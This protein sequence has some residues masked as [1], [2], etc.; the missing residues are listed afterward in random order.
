MVDGNSRSA[1]D[2]V[3]GGIGVDEVR[4]LGF[5]GDLDFRTTAEVEVHHFDQLQSVMLFCTIVVLAGRACIYTNSDIL[6]SE[7]RRGPLGTGRYGYG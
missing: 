6:N 7:N 4:L 1:V 5:K 2:A 3:S